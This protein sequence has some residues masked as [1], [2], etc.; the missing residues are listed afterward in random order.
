MGKGKVFLAGAG[1]GGADLITLR[2][3]RALS[4]ADV[5]LYD[6][7]VPSALLRRIP[8]GIESLCV[9]KRGGMG[10]WSQTDIQMKMA[11]LADAGKTVVR[12]KGGDPFVFGR[13]GEEAEFLSAR[14]IPFEI[15]PGLT[16]GL[17][18][19]ECAG[20]PFTDRRAS[21][22]VVLVTGHEDDSK[23][24]SSVNW[25]ALAGAVDAIIIYMGHGNMPGIVAGLM[26]GGR[27]P[28]TPAALIERG[29]TSDQRVL[30]SKL[31]N[32]VEGARG[33]SAPCIIVVGEVVAL[34]ERLSK[35]EVPPLFGKRIV[36]TRSRDKGLELADDLER[37]GAEVFVLP[38]IETVPIRPNP[39]LEAALDAV[40]SGIA[41]A[42]PG[43][44]WIVFTSSNGVG[45][46]FDALFESGGDCRTLAR[47]K[48]ACI[49]PATAETLRAR[50]ILCDLL[51]ER[52]VSEG[53]AEALIA[54]GVSG[55][56]VL[57]PRAA[58]ANEALPSRLREAGA[59]V[60]E[61]AVYDT[62]APRGMPPGVERLC[63]DEAP[64]YVIFASPSSVRNFIAM[65]GGDAGK[66]LSTASIV[67][68]G[69]V[70]SDECRRLGYNVAVEART[71][72]AEGIIDAILS[73]IG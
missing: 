39:E 61:V 36:V 47:A 20:I 5:V 59:E 3:I 35:L 8:P 64:D 55:K 69:P 65:L 17:A 26:Q 12:L 54:R 43:Y 6:A 42:S 24:E 19:P 31:G 25:P 66:I 73:A 37:L 68:I 48:F 72:T 21:S 53:L 40:L 57:L 50:G 52:Y 70:T 4:E 60:Q 58:E 71:S 2:A 44:D 27:S 9:G 30:I 38:T 14:G 10:G 16:S 29:T 28:D 1:P 23:K 46:F 56:R 7:L 62:I 45:F 32:L 33:Y 22:S 63:G 67:S 51:P 13:G 18:A 11:D 15:I 49:G 41:V 34:K